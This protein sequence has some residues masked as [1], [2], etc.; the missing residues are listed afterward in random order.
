MTK[1][2]IQQTSA[3]GFVFYYDTKHQKYWVLLIK[4]LKSEWWLPKGKLESGE[5]AI[6]AA[7]REINE[8]VGIPA[9][10]LINLGLCEKGHYS[11]QTAHE[12][13]E[14]DLYIYTYLVKDKQEP[15]PIDWDNLAEARWFEYAEAAELISFDKD[16]L[17]RSY[18][19]V[20]KA[21]NG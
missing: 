20:R 6:E 21:A 16:A 10:T 7:C 14:K 4:N 1:R 13:Y 12:I 19:T 9:H 3:G 5:T 2:V 11:Y 18:D 15:S 17:A 8:E